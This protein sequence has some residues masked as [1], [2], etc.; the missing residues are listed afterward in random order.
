MSHDIVADALNQV[1]NAKKAGKKQ[2]EISRYSKFLMEILDIA[3][4]MD[5]LDYKVDSKEKKMTIEIKKL[6]TCK[7]IKPRF[8]VGIDNL[9]KYL[10]RYLPAKNFGFIIISTS[11]G[12]M[13]SNEAYEKNI[14]GSLIAYFY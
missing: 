1:M 12:L 13:T 2:L 14:G 10:R 3:R 11:K 9:D 6:N 5:Y 4:K 8:N 7:V